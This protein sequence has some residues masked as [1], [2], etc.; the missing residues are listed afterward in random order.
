MPLKHQQS[1]TT[2]LR[3]RYEDYHSEEVVDPTDRCMCFVHS[4]GMS[5][6]IHF[7][8]SQ[9]LDNRATMPLSFAI[10]VSGASFP[11]CSAIP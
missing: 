9:A 2:L 8:Y 10:G 6:Q 4:P 3:Y 11:C 7:T 1:E 5:I